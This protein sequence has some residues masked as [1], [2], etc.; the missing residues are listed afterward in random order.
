MDVRYHIDPHNGLPHIYGHGVTEAEVEYVLRN[1]GDDRPGQDDSR[2]ALGQTAAGRYLRV[3][4]VPDP[5]GD[6]VF[7]VTAYD[8]R[9]KQLQ[10]YR[11]RRKR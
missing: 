7:V 11:R 3:I 5:V 1:S 4:Y 2:H 8:L 6:G 9:G 10:A